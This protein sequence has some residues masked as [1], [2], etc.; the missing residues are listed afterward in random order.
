MHNIRRFS[1]WLFLMFMA[2]DILDHVEKM[3]L[4][5]KKLIW[6]GFPSFLDKLQAELLKRGRKID[7]VVD[8]DEAKW[9]YDSHANIECRSPSFLKDCISSS[10]VIIAPKYAKEKTAQAKGYGFSDNQI[11]YVKQTTEYSDEVDRSIVGKFDALQ[12]MSLDDTKECLLH[13]LKVFR[14]FCSRHN[15]RYY[16]AEGTLIGAI[17]HKGF[18]PWDNDLDVFMPYSDYQ[19]LVQLYPSG[20]KHELVC[21]SKHP[22]FTKPYG[23]LIDTSTI[24][25]SK[26]IDWLLTGVG[27]DIF[28]I[29]GFPSGEQERN[30]RFEDILELNKRWTELCLLENDPGNVSDAKAEIE[31]K[32]YNADFDDSEYIGM[33][34]FLEN[35]VVT[36]W[37]V[38]KECFEKTI[39]VEFEG[40]SFK[41]P[42][43][44]DEYLTARYGDYMI[45]P[46]EEERIVHSVLAY[47]KTPAYTDSCFDY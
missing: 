43:G 20:G 4:N 21:W 41:S 36:H 30:K 6:F 27:I 39:D 38:P 12:Q 29:G 11:I 44:Y 24:Y 33:Y 13:T 10:V 32:K 7:F 47:R 9:G 42:A 45:L 15:L 37:A 2:N 14:E 8:N 34:H 31:R 22:D 18:I 25:L 26:Y 16:L 23:K 19:K 17:R 35:T 40:D 1:Y 3:N 28:Q 46:P 5:E